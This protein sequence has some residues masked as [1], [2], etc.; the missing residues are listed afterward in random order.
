MHRGHLEYLYNQVDEYVFMDVQTYEQYTLTKD[1]LG[2][3]VGFLKDLRRLNVAI[4][5][6]R[7]KL[8]CIGNA[9]TLKSHAVYRRFI[10]YVKKKG[11]FV[12]V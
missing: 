6:A 2:E 12:R 5:R 4:T 11:R 3:D 1:D 8:I 7:R 9:E 10:D